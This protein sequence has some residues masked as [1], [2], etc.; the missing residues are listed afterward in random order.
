MVLLQLHDAVLL[1]LPAHSPSPVQPP[2]RHHS[3]ERIAR[4]THTSFGM[5]ALGEDMATIRRGLPGLSPA[6]THP[7]A[8][9]PAAHAASP[10][11]QLPP[12]EQSQCMAAATRPARGHISLTETKKIKL[13]REGLVAVEA[14]RTVTL[15]SAAALRHHPDADLAAM[16]PGLTR[17][18]PELRPPGLDCNVPGPSGNALAGLALRVEE[19][20]AL[21]AS[22][23]LNSSGVAPAPQFQG[24]S[25]RAPLWGPPILPPNRSSPQPPQQTPHSMPSSAQRSSSGRGR[26]RQQACMHLT[27]W[28]L[29]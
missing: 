26:V 27:T 14:S 3:A 29:H 12:A 17:R 22:W 1:C 10:V 23:A 5:N 19:D 8:P 4:P 18:G 24:V 20:R 7:L 16:P 2:Y 15:T 25:E 28:L 21:A 11:H 9:A 13:D 6:A